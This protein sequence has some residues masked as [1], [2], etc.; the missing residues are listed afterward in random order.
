LLRRKKSGFSLLKSRFSFARDGFSTADF[1]TVNMLE[2]VSE[3]E[4]PTRGCPTIRC[5]AELGKF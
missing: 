5:M 1:P 2:A 4:P 3:V